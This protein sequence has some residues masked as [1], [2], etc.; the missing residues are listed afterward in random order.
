LTDPAAQ[1]G[2]FL[3]QMPPVHD[4]GWY[5]CHQR[6]KEGANPAGTVGE[7]Q[8]GAPRTDTQQ[9]E[10]AQGL[11]E[12]LPGPAQTAG[13]LRRHDA[14][15]ADLPK[16]MGAL[17]PNQDGVDGEEHL[18]RLQDRPQMA[19]LLQSE[20]V[21]LAAGVQ[22]PLPIG[23]SDALGR[24]FCPSG[25]GQVHR[26]AQLFRPAR[27]PTWRRDRHE[28]RPQC[29]QIVALPQGRYLRLLGLADDL[30]MRAHQT[31]EYCGAEHSLL[32]RLPA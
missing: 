29:R 25:Q 13:A 2:A 4:R 17:C 14:G 21:L 11:Q 15:G 32:V 5:K 28:L 31:A 12:R 27:T 26:R 20:R 23:L 7:Q 22:H 19:Q 9:R 16:R 30:V 3:P 8:E 10:Y 24:A 1:L 6:P 18:C